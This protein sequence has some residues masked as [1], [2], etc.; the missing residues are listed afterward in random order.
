MED[1]ASY[2]RLILPVLKRYFIKQAAIFGS[3]AKGN[4]HDDSDIDLLIEP[5]KNFTIFKMIKLKEEISE[6]IN[7]KVDLVEYSAIKLSIREEVL[8]SAIRIL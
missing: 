3:F 2:Q 7:R 6:L 1:L 5:G 4:V 8:S